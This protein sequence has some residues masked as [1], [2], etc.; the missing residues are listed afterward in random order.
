MCY[1]KKG[2]GEASGWDCEEWS[3]HTNFSKLPEKVSS[4]IAFGARMA[5]HAARI[6]KPALGKALPAAKPAP[7]QKPLPLPAPLPP[8]AANSKVFS[9]VGMPSGDPR[10][11]YAN[12][13]M[14]G[15]GVAQQIDSAAA[16][17][18][19]HVFPQL[20]YHPLVAAQYEQG[21]AQ[22]DPERFQMPTR[23]MFPKGQQGTNAYNFQLNL[24]QQQ[25][26]QLPAMQAQAKKQLD[27]QLSRH[28]TNLV[29]AR[30]ADL[31]ARPLAGQ[32][33]GALNPFAAITGAAIGKPVYDAQINPQ[34]GIR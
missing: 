31:L 18:T 24:A 8:P 1:A 12:K 17:G 23:G 11:F 27:D 21:Q 10:N 25:R 6:V 34:V 20:K 7:G 29:A 13:Y 9:P 16:G 22:F 4:A 15:E 26:A 32:L 5:K 33:A 28:N 14:W 3:E 19:N 30:G 2:R